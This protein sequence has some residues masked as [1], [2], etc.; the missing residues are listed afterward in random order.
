MAPVT[1]TEDWF[2]PESCQVLADLVREVEGLKGDI[3][4]IGA[5]QGCSTIAM[6]QATRRIVNTV[7]TW[8]GSPN[9]IS[10]DLAAA[11]D[12]HAEFVAN[13]AAA[14]VDNV[15]AWRMDWRTYFTTHLDALRLVFIDAEHTYT[16]VRDTIE[17]VR[18]LL[19]PGGIICGDDAH[20]PPVQRA[21]IDTL[22]NAALAAT[23]WIWRT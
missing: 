9:E 3:V 11:R 16:E 20:H 22:G 1:Y 10:A 8:A 15:V 13:L 6:A 2:G 7:D 14:D 23:L 21:V 12:V 5:W 18:P 19:V 17:T 4:E